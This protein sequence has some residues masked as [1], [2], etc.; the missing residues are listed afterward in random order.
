MM[1]SDRLRQVTQLPGV[2]TAIGH[3]TNPVSGRVGLGSRTARQLTRNGAT[4]YMD[5]LDYVSM[6]AG[7]HGFCMAIESEFWVL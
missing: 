3:D 4:G 5:R 1:S 2:T 7:E 6:V